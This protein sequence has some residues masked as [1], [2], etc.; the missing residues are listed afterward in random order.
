M[1]LFDSHCHIDDP[2]FDADMD[3]MFDRA[4]NA[5]VRAMAIAGV[6]I[7]TARKAVRIAARHRHVITA[8]GIHP[9]DAVHCGPDTL[10]GLIRLA[11][12]ND[13]VKAW[14]ET[15]LDFNRMF[16]P[17]KD[18]EA[19][20]KAQL[21]IAGDLDLPLIFHERDSNGRFY[22]IVKSDGPASRKGV[23]HCFSG[24]RQEMVNYLDLG[25]YI[26]ITG[27]LTIHKR[28]RTLREL[29]TLIPEDR[30]LIE[31]DAPYLTPAP[32]KNKIRRNEPA[33]V[34]SVLTTLAQVRNQDPEDLAAT[35]FNNT[36]RFFN[37]RFT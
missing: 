22:D 5:G 11:K 36:N 1:I 23:V 26:G 10:D 17:Q 7:E 16:S 32:Q 29:A 35:I 37:T 15:G 27:I 8:V 14:G 20:F 2:C 13:C 9:H 34:A 3:A 21:T 30:I 25:Y 18:Q 6:D 24:T 31:T 33:F 19:C 28:G 12:E 4:R